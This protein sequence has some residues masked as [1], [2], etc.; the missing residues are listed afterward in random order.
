MALSA[1]WGF[2]FM[3]EVTLKFRV[4]AE[5]EEKQRRRTKMYYIM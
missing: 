5:V 3:A 4:F 2:L 1:L